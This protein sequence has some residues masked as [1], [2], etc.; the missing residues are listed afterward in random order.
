M[1]SNKIKHTKDH[2]PIFG[3][4]TYL[5]YEIENLIGTFKKRKLTDVSMNYASTN[6]S[7][8]GTFRERGLTI[9]LHN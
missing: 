2:L 3:Q 8:L 5:N 9:Q 7:T 6:L 4:Y 1:F